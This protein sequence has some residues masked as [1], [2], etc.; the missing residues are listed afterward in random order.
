M[1]DIPKVKTSDLNAKL[2][3]SVSA[4]EAVREGIATHAQKHRE[5]MHEARKL[6]AQQRKLAEKGLAQITASS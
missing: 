1:T 6:A 4:A 3:G 2:A 5:A